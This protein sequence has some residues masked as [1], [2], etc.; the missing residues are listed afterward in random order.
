MFST[1]LRK[2][3]ETIHRHTGASRDSRPY[4]QPLALLAPAIR[5]ILQDD[6]G[7]LITQARHGTRR[8][9]PRCRALQQKGV[10][11]Y[12][13]WSNRVEAYRAS[14]WRYAG[15]ERD[16]RTSSSL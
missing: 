6:M 15:L 5:H 12:A 11:P 2:E 7:T 9:I 3:V 4:K 1:R 10:T 16:G 14:Q 8:W 13:G